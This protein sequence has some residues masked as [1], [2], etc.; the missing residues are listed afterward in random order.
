MVTI[1]C[2]FIQFPVVVMTLRFTTIKLS[3]AMFVYA[4][5]INVMREKPHQNIFLQ[6]ITSSRY[7]EI[8][9]P[10]ALSFLFR[11]VFVWYTHIDNTFFAV[12]KK[13]GGAIAIE[14]TAVAVVAVAVGGVFYF[15]AAGN[16]FFNVFRNWQWK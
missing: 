1:I 14:T 12:I 7:E 6:K 5:R 16:L 2:I 10:L 9:F 3:T 8:I 11:R 13:V 4:I 15:D